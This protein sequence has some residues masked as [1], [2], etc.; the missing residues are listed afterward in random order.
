MRY[1]Y[2]L[3]GNE[4][5]LGYQPLFDPRPEVVADVQRAI[6]TESHT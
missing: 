4:T 3:E 5:V 1:V 2:P 6:D